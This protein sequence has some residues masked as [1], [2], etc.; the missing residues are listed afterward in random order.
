M[1]PRLAGLPRTP[2][3]WLAEI[4]VP[5]P[6]QAGIPAVQ[7]ESAGIRAEDE[8]KDLKDELEAAV[9]AFLWPYVHV[10]VSP[11]C[12]SLAA[13]RQMSI[14]GGINNLWLLA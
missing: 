1:P 3:N 5:L 13:E 10:E 9:S 6:E 4:S 2:V 7:G 11:P 14:P 8:D 12:F